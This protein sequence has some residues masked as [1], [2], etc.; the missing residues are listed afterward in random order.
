[1]ISQL[2]TE[3]ADFD[4]TSEQTVLTHTPSTSVSMRCQALL[5]IGDGAKD[6]DGTG[7]NFTIGITI[8]GVNVQPYPETVAFTAANVRTCWCS[9]EFTVP[10]NEAVTVT[11]TSPNGADT[12]VDVTA[13]LYDVNAV[14]VVAVSGDATAA[15]N[16]ELMYDGTGYTDD[17]APA[18][19]SQIAN[20]VTTGAATHKSASSATI[21]TGSETGTYANTV[22]VDG[23]YHQI[24][25]AGTEIDMYYEFNVGATGVPTNVSMTGRLYDNTISDTIEVYAYDWGNTQWQQM[26]S[27]ASIKTSD[28]VYN[29]TLFTQHVGTGDDNG[30]VRIRFYNASL[31]AGTVLYVDQVFI[32]YATVGSTV[33]YAMGR[34]WVDTTSGVAG[35]TDHVNGVADN[36][37]LTWADALTLAASLGIYLF[38]LANG[39]EIT[40]T[41]DSSYYSFAGA[42]TIHLGGQVITNAHFEGMY[43]IDGISSGDDAEFHRCGIGT[44]TIA[45]SYFRDCNF[46]GTFT[47]VADDDYFIMNGMDTAGGAASQVIFVFKANVEVMFRDYNGGLE[48]QDM[49]AT[50]NMI[51]DGAGRL[52]IDASC[53]AGSIT[54]RGFFPESTGAAA[55]IAAGGTIT[56]DQ[57]YSEAALATAAALTAHDGKLDTVD[58]NVDLVLEDTAEL[59]EN[60]GN[61]VTATG[62]ATSGELATHDGKLDTA[63]GT[64]TK[65]EGMFELDGAV[66]KF[67]ANALEEAAGGGDATLANQTSI[68]ED[69][70]DMKGTA[71][72]KDTNSLVNLATSVDLTTAQGTITKLDGMLVLDGAV[73]K[74]TANALE[75]A[76]GGGDATL[77]NQ[78]LILEDLEDVKGTDF[79]K[80]T[81]S[82][83]DLTAADPINVTVETTVV[84]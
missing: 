74:F 44:A 11:L 63:Q 68:L 35:T 82:L 16:L 69:I 28:E 76:A 80:D 29:F 79:V 73:Y 78:A 17:T 10:A 13:Y 50:N 21:T 60:Q 2:D 20:I 67:T 32:G 14:D 77:A 40:L 42:A 56:D 66:Y 47:S 18:S 48:I 41:A 64:L 61:W 55:F 58:G 83:V 37:V 54:L 4:L 15:D 57:T 38:N 84:E 23:S 72:A 24:D 12:D 19:R 1:M 43:L 31:D 53:T 34:I 3:N 33:G 51:I 49:A 9:E 8:G 25:R 62:F 6:L 27:I 5:K 22:G 36:P 65:L 75:E 81:N 52:V 30:K 45:H 70:V 46:K 39:S 7:G 59:Q 71:F 26:S